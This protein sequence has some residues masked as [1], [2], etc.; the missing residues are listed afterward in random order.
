MS[1]SRLVSAVGLATGLAVLACGSDPEPTA[2]PANGS[3]IADVESRPVVVD[4]DDFVVAD[5]G[6][7]LFYEVVGDGE[8]VVLVPLHYFLRDAFTAR[9]ELLS[10]RTLV[11]YDVRN[12]GRSAPVDDLASLSLYQDV[13]DLESVRRHV[14]AER[15]SLIGFSY[16][17]KMVAMYAM[18]HPDRVDRVV[19]LGPVARDTGKVYAPHLSASDRIESMGERAVDDLRRLQA[20]GAQ[21]SAPREFC[22]REWE[23]TR[24]ALVGD[25]ANAERI[26]HPC[27]LEREWPV[28]LQQHY[29]NLLVANQRISPT[30]EEVAALT[31]PVLVIHG[32]R[33]RHAPYGSG[34]DWAHELPQAR[35]LTVDGAAHCAWVDEPAVVFAAMARF[36]DGEWPEGVEIVER[37]DPRVDP[38]DEV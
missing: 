8:D 37:P 33:D 20:E 17:G 36:L 26:P 13:A 5:D 4:E 22:E 2:A 35:L 15:V 10:G 7:R 29:Q 28:N 12:R 38:D 27:D 23:V 30:A 9:P 31:L 21:V 34:R 32:T 11:F 16:L 25:P 14:G 19:Q 18:R 24:R 1:Y 6:A 3:E